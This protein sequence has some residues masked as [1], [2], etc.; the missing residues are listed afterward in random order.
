MMALPGVL[1][2]AA[3][4]HRKKMKAFVVRALSVIAASAVL[5]LI[6]IEIGSG[7]PLTVARG[8]VQGSVGSSS[9]LVA[10]L[11]QTTPLI[12]AAL[13]FA[14]AFRSGVFNAGGQ[15][16]F[17]MGAF[18]ASLAGFEHPF[19]GLPAPL[20]LALVLISG[21]AFGAAWSAVPILLKIWRGIDEILTS[22][23]LSYAADE[24][25]SWLVLGPFKNPSVQPG[26]NSQTPLLSKTATFPLLVG[27]SS[28]TFMIIV[29]CALCVIAWLYYRY[30]VP[31]YESL[32]IGG[33]PRL[34]AI[35]GVRVKRK[36]LTAMLC[37]GAI[38]GLAGAS[39]VG[40]FFYSDITPFGSNVGFN[41]I[42]AAL[43]VGGL[44]LAI[45]F[46]ALFFGALQ[47]G[48]LGLQIFSNQSQYIADV[49]TAV[50]IVFVAMR[51]RPVAWAGITKRFPRARSRGGPAAVVE[52][53]LATAQRVDPEPVGG[54]VE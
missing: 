32:L 23:M 16:Q 11:G 52:S 51:R 29:A 18:G 38:A 21:A 53:P 13:S 48:G 26:A 45:P 10:T 33:N 22:L 40:G 49:L 30:T 50:V 2:L 25:N 37:S 15:G 44:P 24:L 4:A 46:G 8:L 42:L 36:M 6:I 20:H 5:G 1:G 54:G 31:G 41:G 27:G 9:A 39:V 28:L 12:F 14:V 3:R 43:L 19:V 17:E 47:Q 35:S 7:N 34:A